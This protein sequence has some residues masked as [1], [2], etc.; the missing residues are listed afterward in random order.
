[1]STVTPKNTVAKKIA[2]D[3]NVQNAG[4]IG[5]ATN[6][7]IV[8]PGFRQR[9]NSLALAYGPRFNPQVLPDSGLQPFT[10]GT[11]LIDNEHMVDDAIMQTWKNSGQ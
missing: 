8:T 2:Y 1:M 3:G 11:Y 7:V 9:Y 4:V 5:F 6:G 10:N